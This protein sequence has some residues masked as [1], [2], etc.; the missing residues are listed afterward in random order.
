MNTYRMSFTRHGFLF[1]F[2][3]IAFFLFGC[4]IAEHEENNVVITVGSRNISA[5]GLK[6]D[7]EFLSAGMDVPE[8]QQADIWNQ[9]TEQLI[10]YYL[11][12]EYGKK[13]GIFITERELR[14]ALDD[15]KRDYSEDMFKKTLLREYVD[16]DQWKDR[17]KEK[18][19]INKILKKVTENITPP[20][21]KEIERYFEERHDE[22]RCPQM[23]R[24]RQIITRTKEDAANILKRIQSGEDMGELARKF[25]IAPEAESSGEVG[26]V[27]LNNLDEAIGK[28]L[29]SMPPGRKSPVVKT[30]YGYHI[31]EVLSVQ[32]ESVKKLP[33]VIQQIE[34]TL[35]NQER[36]VFISKWID[37]LRTHFDVRVNQG[38]LSELELN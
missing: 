29:F 10:D 20:S 8:R 15:V 4:G 28:V 19:L 2:F 26:W 9:L 24:F 17:F 25:S 1:G 14:S 37:E 11:I 18:L 3:S 35:L 7:M 12:L 23:V 32:P 6:K 38:L 16:F 36:E 21:H 5:D 30:P 34:S 33:E 31:F 22:F 13:N 27:A